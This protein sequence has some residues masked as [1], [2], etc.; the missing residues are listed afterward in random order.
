MKNLKYVIN[1]IE[2][3]DVALK[4]L[5]KSLIDEGV[6]LDDIIYVYSNSDKFHI[7]YNNDGIKS[8]YVPVNLY[9]FS[10]L[11]GIN[12]LIA[13]DKTKK[14]L[15][16]FNYLFLHDT[17]KAL[18]GFR[19]KSIQMNSLISPQGSC[20]IY[21]AHSSGRHNIGIFSAN[22]VLKSYHQSL[23]P[24][25]EKKEV[26]T[27]EYAVQMEWDRVPESL[28]S[29]N[30]KQ[31]YPADD[32]GIVLTPDYCRSTLYSKDKPRSIAFLT[33]LNL[34]KYYY[35]LGAIRPGNFAKDHPQSV[36]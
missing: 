23:K 22:A 6:D 36:I 19:Q 31:Q 12:L 35:K 21:W 10:S 27:K 33:S 30:V 5:H 11:L 29:I 15:E 2:H 8:V 32:V 16:D 26:F 34:V 14:Y 24:I 9:E 3:Y 4:I 28:R 20:E 7:G 25:I 17:C 13:S 18:K 1:T